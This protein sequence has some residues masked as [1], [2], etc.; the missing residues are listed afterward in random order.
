MKMFCNYLREHAGNKIDFEKKKMLTLKN[1]LKL[2]QEA[3]ISYICVKRFIQKLD[4]IKIMVKL[5]TVA[6]LLADTEVQ[7]ILYAIRNIMR[8][9][10]LLC[11]FKMS[12]IMITILS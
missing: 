4:K 6:I 9:T 11:F 8:Q 5:E 2:H 3:K 7:R 10:K 12:Q 1:E